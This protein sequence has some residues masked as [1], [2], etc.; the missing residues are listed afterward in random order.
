MPLRLAVAAALGLATHPAVAATMSEGSASYVLLFFDL[1]PG[2]TLEA[3]E[4]VE[5]MEPDLFGVVADGSS[6]GAGGG[7]DAESG[8]ANSDVEIDTDVAGAPAF[9]E[10]YALF[11]IV[12]TLEN[13][14]EEALT[15]SDEIFYDL[16]ASVRLDDPLLDE[17]SAG[18][19]IEVLVDGETAF[20]EEV[21]QDAP[22]SVAVEDE[23]PLEFP[24]LAGGM[25]EVAI[26]AEAFATAV[27]VSP[28]PLPGAWSLMAAALGG[29]VLLGRRHGLAGDAS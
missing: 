20:L 28:I 19:W 15:V 23:A 16:S 18:A 3:S 22:G 21:L 1:P 8:S 25:S 11:S 2:V 27:D 26:S 24:L 5:V 12:L 29:L 9:G 13:T 7:I 10:G 14:T 6:A 4:P 17:A